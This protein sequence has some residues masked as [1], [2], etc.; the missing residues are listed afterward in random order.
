MNEPMRTH[1]RTERPK[2]RLALAIFA[3]F[4]AADLFAVLWLISVL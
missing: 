4:V 3:T 1:M 2:P